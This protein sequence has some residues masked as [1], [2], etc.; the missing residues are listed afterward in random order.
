MSLIG[1]LIFWACAEMTCGFFIFSMPCLS[2]MFM[3]SQLSR[4][5][6]IALGISAA[7]SSTLSHEYSDSPPQKKP[8]KKRNNIEATWPRLSDYSIPL[9]SPVTSESQEQLHLAFHPELDTTRIPHATTVKDSAESPTG[10]GPSLSIISR[11]RE[12]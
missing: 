12:P 8:W 9:R 2:K 10:D 6:Q 1:P 4:K 11:A 5:M 7:T 3:D